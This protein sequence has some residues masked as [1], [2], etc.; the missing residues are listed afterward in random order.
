MEKYV[1]NKD[2]RE[3]C[4][5]GPVSYTHL[6]QRHSDKTVFDAV[7]GFDNYIDGVSNVIFHTDNIQNLRAFE[8]AIRYQNSDDGLKA[9]IDEINNDGDLSENERQSRISEL[10]RDREKTTKFGDFV[11]WLNRYTNDLAGKKSVEDRTWEY[12]MGRGMY[13][14]LIH[15]SNPQPSKSRTSKNGSYMQ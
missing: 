13:L 2:V 6:L 9:Q 8:E 4:G 11:S 5:I 14:S 10:F 1:S 7:R 15:I 3:M 12:N